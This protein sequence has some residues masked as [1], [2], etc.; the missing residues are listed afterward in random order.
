MLACWQPFTRLAS[1]MSGSL[2]RGLDQWGTRPQRSAINSRWAILPQPGDRIW[3]VGATLEARRDF[4]DEGCELK[5][6]GENLGFYG[7]YRP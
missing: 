6:L 5:E 3:V 7:A 1:I 2:L 4:L